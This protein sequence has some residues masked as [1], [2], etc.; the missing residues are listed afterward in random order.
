M[1]S[2]VFQ[3]YCGD[4]RLLRQFDI[5]AETGTPGRLLVKTFHGITPD[6]EGNIV[7]SFIPIENRACVN[8]I[9][10]TDEGKGPTQ[11]AAH[12]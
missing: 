7:L 10:I 9:E 2:R 8:A 12:P 6:A 5:L 1:G 11:A 3:V 4:T